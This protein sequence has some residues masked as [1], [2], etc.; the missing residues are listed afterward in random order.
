MAISKADWSSAWE[1]RGRLPSSKGRRHGATR[2]KGKLPEGR[3]PAQRSSAP[4]TSR[5]GE[6]ERFRL[7][8][9]LRDQAAVAPRGM[10]D[11][12]LA[13]RAA[14]AMARYYTTDTAF[15]LSGPNNVPGAWPASLITPYATHRRERS[16][17]RGLTG[18]AVS[19]SQRVRGNYSII[20]LLI[21]SLS[22]LSREQRASVAD[23]QAFQQLSK[24]Q[25]PAATCP[26]FHLLSRP[27]C[28]LA[29]LVLHSF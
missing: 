6:L 2:A 21:Y 10:V 9:R 3:P 23:S 7:S 26:E 20:C 5:H 1:A 27:S 4:V 24:R 25:G 19:P 17:K 22:P 28:L 18:D 29:C 13:P 11:V 15:P 12:T 8:D 14:S 16:R